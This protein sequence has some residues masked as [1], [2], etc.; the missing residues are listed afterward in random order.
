MNATHIPARLALFGLLVAALI[1]VA[2]LP[3]LAE[4]PLAEEPAPVPF[5]DPAPWG[6]G[7]CQATETG[8]RHGEWECVGTLFPVPLEW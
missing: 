5:P 2:T 8:G 1:L 3:A 7:E 6:G 4:A